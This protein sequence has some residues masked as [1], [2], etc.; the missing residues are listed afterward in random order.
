MYF[1][2]Y[3]AINTLLNINNLSSIDFMR[4][5][6]RYI[7]CRKVNVK[8]NGRNITGYVLDEDQYN[9]N[10]LLKIDLCIKVQKPKFIYFVGTDE[11]IKTVLYQYEEITADN[12]DRYV[13]TEF[14]TIR[15]RVMKNSMV[16]MIYLINRLVLKEDIKIHQLLSS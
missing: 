10:V 9:L 15:I 4:E 3:G 11:K 13:V 8:K 16:N 14:W 1:N 7:C 5:K 12:M 2:S 6:L